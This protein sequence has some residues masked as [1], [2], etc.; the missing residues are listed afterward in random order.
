[1]RAWQAESTSDKARR[2]AEERARALAEDAVLVERAR[3]AEEEQRRRDFA[4]KE[5]QRQIIEASKRDNEERLQ[6][7]Y[8]VPYDVQSPR[9][10]PRT[11]ALS[12]F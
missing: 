7:W 10:A 3:E 2:A 9:L 11:R 12:R 6:V 4:K 8:R 1:M 5:Q